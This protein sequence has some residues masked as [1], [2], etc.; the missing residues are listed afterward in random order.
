MTYQ[1]LKERAFDEGL[2]VK[3][4]DIPGYKGRIKGNRIAIHDGL[5]TS[6]EKAC[7]LAEEIG[8][9]VTTVGDIH[10][11]TDP[12]AIRQ[13]FIAR[14]YAFEMQIGISGLIRAYRRCCRTYH[15]V[16]EELN[17]TVP[18]LQ[19]A[20]EYYRMKYGD[21]VLDIDGYSVCFNPQLSIMIKPDPEDITLP[22][23]PVQIKVAAEKRA[24]RRA[25][26]EKPV[27]KKKASARPKNYERL[28]RPDE[29]KKLGI[30]PK[31]ATILKLKVIDA[32][33][34]MSRKKFNAWNDELRE[35]AKAHGFRW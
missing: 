35:N 20:L 22:T 30:D 17:V 16:A 2:I 15:E 5:E 31:L 3:E 4:Y 7:V 9:A 6:E 29:Y 18:F 34:T 12:D 28:L 23:V 11:R 25:A 26:K 10:D 27:S 21:K 13:E 33:P 8:H 32:P 19:D 14:V 1:E 24:Q